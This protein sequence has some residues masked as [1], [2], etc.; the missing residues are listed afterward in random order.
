LKKDVRK[1]IGKNVEKWA[2]GKSHTNLILLGFYRFS[3]IQMVIHM[4]IGADNAVISLIHRYILNSEEEAGEM[5]T[6]RPSATCE[7]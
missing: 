1:S 7:V 6:K 3:V 4:K 2:R 5:L